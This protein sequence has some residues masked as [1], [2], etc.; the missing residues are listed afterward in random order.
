MEERKKIEM[1]NCHTHTFLHKDVPEK[2]LP[3]GLVRFIAERSVR[4]AKILNKL[5]PGT[6]GDIY[7]R[8]AN[9]L[10]LMKCPSQEETF[11]Y[12]LH[13]YPSNTRFVILSMDMN[14]MGAGDVPRDFEKQLDELALLREKYVGRVLPFI[15]ID[16][17]RKDIPEIVKKYIE[18]KNF[19]GLK[20]YPPL[21]YFPYDDRLTPIY[22][23][24]ETHGLPI[25]AHCSKSG[26]I[27][28]REKKP[29]LITRIK[30]QLDSDTGIK[31][32]FKK[33]NR[34]EI[35]NYFTHPLNYKILFKKFPKLKICL[36]HFGGQSQWIKFLNPST[37][38][39]CEDN[40]VLQKDEE[41]SWFNTIYDMMKTEKT[42]HTDVSFTL[43]NRDFF[44][45]LKVILS[46][47]QVKEQILFGS[48]FYMVEAEKSERSFGI[49]L[50][51]YLGTDLFTLI[52]ETNPKKFLSNC[53]H[54]SL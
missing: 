17:R 47:P 32:T 52:S 26:P 16:P 19:C 21:G 48:D 33:K 28:S 29:Q 27:Y 50:H 13:F 7:D 9:F 3:L 14:Y 39:T 2:F 46:N 44:P 4:I 1:H 34:K 35:C 8:Y 31:P 15:G 45:L 30:E 41:D 5:I 38:G 49:D 25:I 51:G 42:L 37:A 24:A 6:D 43:E 20:L 22:K 23:Y 10:R 54:K 40:S 12:L 36:A 18:E 53:I 11:R